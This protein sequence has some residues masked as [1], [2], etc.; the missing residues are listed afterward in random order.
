MLNETFVDAFNSRISV[1]VNTVKTMTA[2]QMDRVKAL[3]DQA[4]ELLKNK[5]L[6]LFVHTTRIELLDTTT[7]ITGHTEQDNNRRIAVSNQLAGLEAFV[8]QLKTA[9]RNRNLVVKQLAS[10]GAVPTDII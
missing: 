7:S 6:A 5:N 10:G 8:D 3:G 9:V 4:E 1:N 2:A